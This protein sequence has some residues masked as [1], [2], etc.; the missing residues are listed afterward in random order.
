MVREDDKSGI[1]PKNMTVAFETIKSIAISGE[2]G[3]GKTSVAKE[4]GILLGWDYF[5]AGELF[6]EWCALHS[7]PTIGAQVEQ[8]DIHDIIDEKMLEKMEKGR[9]VV[10]GRVAGVLA[11]VNN[12]PGVLK[13]MLVCEAEER[14]RRIYYRDIEKYS[15]IQ[16]AKEETISRERDN[17]REFSRR[18]KGLSYM[19]SKTYDLIIDTNEHGFDA[20]VRKVLDTTRFHINK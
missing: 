15:S 18:Y 8:D 16:I 4:L 1:I 17:K 14:Y 2:A 11:Y 3:T 13:V 6:R 10:E 7:R 20:V 9:S 12:I 19:E 5:G